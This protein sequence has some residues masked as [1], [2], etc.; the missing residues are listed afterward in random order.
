MKKF[1]AIKVSTGKVMSEW[2]SDFADEKYYEENWG[3]PEHQV[4]LSPRQVINHEEVPAVIENG[5]EVSPA[6]PA[7]DEV[8]E[9][10]FETVPSEYLL[11][12][13]DVTAEVEQQRINVEALAYLAA[14]DWLI[15][16]ESET[17]VVCPA[18]IKLERAAAR[19]R[20]K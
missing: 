7:Y 10:T 16:R 17:Q 5:V 8:I 1:K 12:I 11:E 14:T 15:V 2:D 19:L 6:I 20:I 18:D 4:E 9:A 3:K 13:V